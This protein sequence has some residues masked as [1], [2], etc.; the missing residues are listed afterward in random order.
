MPALFFWPITSV[1]FLRIARRRST[2]HHRSMIHRVAGS[3]LVRLDCAFWPFWNPTERTQTLTRCPYLPNSRVC[4]SALNVFIII[5]KLEH[6]FSK[7]QLF[8]R[9]FE[10]NPQP[11]MIR[12]RHSGFKSRRS[13]TK[14]GTRIEIS[15]F[16]IRDWV[17]KNP[18][19]G[20]GLSLGKSGIPIRKTLKSRSYLHQS[21]F[22]N[23]LS[24]L[25]Y[26]QE[27]KT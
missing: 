8:T 10:N 24:P 12:G 25:R 1:G 13:R 7:F 2:A 17:L 11:V 18:D 6:T 16:G 21:H 3:W 14:I 23:C 26:F 4:I 20:S 22:R 15:D 19:L 5:A 27:R 9:I